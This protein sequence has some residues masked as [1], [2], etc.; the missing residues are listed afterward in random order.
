M[1]RALDNNE[2]AKIAGRKITM[3]LNTD[4]NAYDTL[5]KLFVT[6]CVLLNYLVQK[7]FGHWVGLHYDRDKEV[8][9]FFDSYGKLPDKALSYIPMKYRIESNQEYPYLSKLMINWLDADPRKRRKISYNDDQLQRYSSKIQTCGR[10]VGLWFRYCNQLTV[11]AF[12]NMM[13][14]HRDR[15]FSEYAV[16]GIERDLFMDRLVVRLTDAFLEPVSLHSLL[17]D[18]EKII[19]YR[20]DSKLAKIVEVDGSGSNCQCGLLKCIC[21]KLEG[22]LD[23]YL[24]DYTD[25]D[26]DSDSY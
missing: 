25:P 18:D 9:T 1:D 8:I 5:E 2:V 11:E 26:S 6:D 17:E 3:V 7:D 13:E 24:D 15:Y 10:W 19:G 4:M 20:G 14:G 12:E 22:I 16:K 23:Q 21:D